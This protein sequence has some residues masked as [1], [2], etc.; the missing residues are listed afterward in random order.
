MRLNYPDFDP[1]LD[2][3]S[4]PGAVSISNTDRAMS[5][6]FPDGWFEKLHRDAITVETPAVNPLAEA[7]SDAHDGVIMDDPDSTQAEHPAM[8]VQGR[9][10]Y[11]RDEA[12]VLVKIPLWEPQRPVEPQPEHRGAG[13]GR[14][15]AGFVAA[16]GMLG[17]AAF[18]AKGILF[19]QPRVTNT[20]TVRNAPTWTADSTHA[21]NYAPTATTQPT[22]TP[23]R[24]KPTA[25]PTE[26][27]TQPSDPNQQPSDHYETTNTSVT[28]GGRQ[29]GANS[30]VHIDYKTY[31][32]G[33]LYYVTDT[34]DNLPASDFVNSNDPNLIAR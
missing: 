9:F 22:K 25:T 12:G 24:P 11:E 7:G 28:F 13:R 1:S 4:Q 2:P 33:V 23:P 16:V 17:V 14:L 27:P 15:A 5:T 3:D 31:V 18:L 10:R 21:T 34:G 32:G 20:N 19:D 26:V 29:Y 30:S 8:H 6:H